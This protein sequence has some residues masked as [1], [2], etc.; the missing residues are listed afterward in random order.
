MDVPTVST[1]AEARILSQ[2]CDFAI[3]VVPFGKVT[4]GQVMS[5]IDAVGRERFAGLV[6]NN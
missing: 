4:I 6:F 1:T 2:L 3:L 5:G